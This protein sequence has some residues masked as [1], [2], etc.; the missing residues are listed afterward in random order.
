MKKVLLFGLAILLVLSACSTSRQKLSPQA[1]LNLKSANV[2]YTQ[3][4]NEASLA[5]SLTLYNKVLA[6]NPLQITAL[7]RTADINFY[8]ATQIEPLV[9]DKNGIKEY[10]RLDKARNAINLYI[11]TY[12]KYDSVLTVINSFE[13]LN[14][15]ERSMKRDAQKKK[16]GSWVRI[17]K[18]GQILFDNTKYDEAIFAFETAN[19]IDPSKIEP[20]KM[21]VACYQEKKDEPKIEL[22]LAKVLEK[23]PNDAGMIKMMGAQYYYKKDYTNAL[24]YFKQTMKVAPLDINNL[25]LMANSYSYLKDYQSSLEAVNKVLN[26]EP[27]NLEA[28]AFAKDLARNLN[29]RTAE[30]DYMKRL[31]SVDN[32][33]KNLATLCYLLYTYEMYDGLMDYAERWYEKDSTSK[34]AVQMCMLIAD[35]TA[36]K[37]L[38]KKYS[39]IYKTLQ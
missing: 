18:I 2:Y 4:D 19:K 9:D 3:K 26:L 30:V 37:D 17:F 31:V 23:D 21:L 7:K 32:S 10:S 20:L 8:Y 11:I 13:K 16:D 38:V 15:D 24:V 5:K 39:D 6:D 36:R 1:N 14:D 28:L 25:L 33:S 22:Y 27:E 12:G 34:E 35:K 29:N